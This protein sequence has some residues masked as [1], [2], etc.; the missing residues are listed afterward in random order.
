MVSSRILFY[1]ACGLSPVLAAI[2]PVGRE[3]AHR[4]VVGVAQDVITVADE[5]R[6]KRIILIGHSMGE[7]VSLEAAHRM[8]P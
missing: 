8:L 2:G 4:S 3:R 1:M 6:P 7:R 5:L